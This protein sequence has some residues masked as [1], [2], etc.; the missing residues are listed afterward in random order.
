[1]NKHIELV[2]KWLADPA[3]VSQE[4]LEEN[5]VDAYDATS[6]AGGAYAACYANADAA[7]EVY[8]SSAAYWVKRYK[9]LSK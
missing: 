5:A 2:M 8:G 6:S 7:A 4:E 1:M 3:S 9:E